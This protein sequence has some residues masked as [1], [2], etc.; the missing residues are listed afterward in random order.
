M[1]TSCAPH[2]VEFQPGLLSSHPNLLARLCP[3]PEVSVAPPPLVLGVT[4]LQGGEWHPNSDEWIDSLTLCILC[5]CMPRGHSNIA[6]DSLPTLQIS[7]GIVALFEKIYDGEPI[8]TGF[9]N[10][11]E[12]VQKIFRCFS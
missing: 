9:S 10:I 8:F 12:D 1:H 5:A 4:Y 3:P 7:L 2:R 11:G 6:I